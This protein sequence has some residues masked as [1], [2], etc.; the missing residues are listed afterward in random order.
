MKN[1]ILK[2]VFIL[3]G[4]T[5]I[6]FLFLNMDSG[7]GPDYKSLEI[8]QNI[9]GYLIVDSVY[10]A[11]IHSWTYDLAYKYKSPDNKI[12]DLGTGRIYGPLEWTENEQLI[13]Y[14]DWITLQVGNSIIVGSLNS[15]K[16]DKYD[17]SPKDIEEQPLWI[18]S[19]V[20]SSPD[21]GSSFVR[22]QTISTDG[23]ITILYTYAIK[24][25]TFSSEI[26]KKIVKYEINPLTGIPEMK[27]VLDL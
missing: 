13:K 10:N 3:V 15:N 24:D 7:F 4:L 1:K 14:K 22:I 8:K 20:N 27:D 11:D 18:N 16:W 26:G 9:G 6:Y 23:E 5:L 17:F 19:K 25:R 12:Y 2:I 21:N